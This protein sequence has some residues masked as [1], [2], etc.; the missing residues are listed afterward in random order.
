MTDDGLRRLIRLAEE[1]DRQATARLCSEAGL[2]LQ[3]G[4]KLHPW[5]QAYLAGALQRVPEA[6]LRRAFAPRGRQPPETTQARR[7]MDD[8]ALVYWVDRAIASGLAT[9][10]DGEP[11]PAFADCAA[12]LHQSPATVRDRYYK[13]R[14]QIRSFRKNSKNP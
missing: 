2:A 11:G 10:R 5:L 4:D 1:G 9:S 12:A 13:V 7:E 3:R 8:L 14:D 6:G